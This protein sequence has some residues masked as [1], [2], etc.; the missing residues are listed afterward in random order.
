[1]DEIYEIDNLVPK[2]KLSAVLKAMDCDEK[3]CAY[4]EIVNEYHEI[5]DKLLKLAEPVGILGFGTLPMV[6]E[7]EK[8]KEGTPVIYAVLSIG[9]RIMQCSTKA[10]QEGDYV[11]GMLCDAIA[12]SILFSLEDRMLEKLREVCREHKKGILK[13]LEAP[14]DIPMEAQRE[15]WERLELKK[16]FGIDISCGFMLDPVKTSCQVFVLTGD[17][18]VFQA[19]HDCRKCPNVHCKFRNIPEI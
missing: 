16:R 4:G 18:T 6:I 3:S 14:H 5:C 8:Y 1:M 10:F 9:D 13:R 17:E 7:T 12:D 11:K 15:A 2:L 19:Q